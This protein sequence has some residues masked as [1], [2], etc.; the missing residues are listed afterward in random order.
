[1]SDLSQVFKIV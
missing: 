1:M